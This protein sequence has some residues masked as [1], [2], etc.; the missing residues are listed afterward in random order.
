MTQQ[1]LNSIQFRTI[2]QQMCSERMP[3]NMRRDIRQFSTPAGG[4]KGCS[5]ALTRLPCSGFSATSCHED[6]EELPK[7]MCV[8]RLS[9]FSALLFQRH[10]ND[11][12][13]IPR[14]NAAVR[15][16]RVGPVHRTQLAAV[17]RI[18]SGLDELGPA[19]FLIAL[20]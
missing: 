16:C 15:V 8:D 19:D 1:L 2:V 13:V 20:R 4:F 11:L 9:L 12:F 7:R 5:E 3:E 6:T 18:G 10:G 17:P 14:D